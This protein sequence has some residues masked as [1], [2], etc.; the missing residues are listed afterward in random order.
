MTDTAHN[1]PLPPR[2]LVGFDASEHSRTALDRAAEEAVLRDVPLEILSGWPW[3]LLPP[4]EGQDTGGSTLHDR[5]RHLVDNAAEELRK[6]Y[7]KLRVI[8]SMTSEAAADA[9]A[10][11]S[12]GA[13][14]TVVGS[15]GHGGFAGLLL[16]SVSLRVAAHTASPL[17]VVRGDTGRS[18]DRVLLGVDADTE[19]AAIE[20]AFEEAK[21]HDAE[22]H[23]VHAFDFAPNP[24]DVHHAAAAEKVASTTVA[25]VAEGHPDV[26]LRTETV[27]G[28]PRRALVEASEQA[29]VVVVGRH[30]RRYRFGMQLGPV[31]HSV[32]HHSHCPVVLVPGER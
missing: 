31:L 8:P 15:R 10:H 32:L 12:E 5:S 1:A 6:R 28:S 18:H 19:R 13:V 26:R 11:R 16:G 24:E 30:H 2:V 27:Q 9:L 17:L 7:P 3:E 25:A 29:D 22:L 20:F 4:M 21:R 14:L 23:V